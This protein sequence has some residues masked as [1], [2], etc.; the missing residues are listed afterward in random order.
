MVQVT[1][2]NA[3]TVGL[4]AVLFLFAWNM[5]ARLLVDRNPDSELG[6]AMAVVTNVSG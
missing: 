2:L 3:I 4:M 6:K 1:T 5:A